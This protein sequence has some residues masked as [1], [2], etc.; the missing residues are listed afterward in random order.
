MLKNHDAKRR[1]EVYKEGWDPVVEAMLE[2]HPEVFKADSFPCPIALPQ[3]KIASEGFE[4]PI[5]GDDRALTTIKS[6]ED[7][8]GQK[9][10]IA[11]SSSD[12]NSSSSEEGSSF[13]SDTE[14]EPSSK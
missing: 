11:F 6:L 7:G 3:T 14:E 4:E 13:S 5:R 12:T 1:P 2:A 8:R 10:K 9:R